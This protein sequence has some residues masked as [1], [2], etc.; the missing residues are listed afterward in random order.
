MTTNQP[1]KVFQD[2]FD[3]EY[4]GNIWGWKISYIGLALIVFFTALIAY[5]HYSLGIPL[6]MEPTELQQEP[7]DSV[8]IQKD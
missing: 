6:G 4:L 7:T 2:P 8:A 3:G 5:R 1:K